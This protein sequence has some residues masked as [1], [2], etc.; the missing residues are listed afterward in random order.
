MTQLVQAIAQVTADEN[1]TVT[2]SDFGTYIF[3]DGETTFQAT[4]AGDKVVLRGAWTFEHNGETI[5][6][7]ENSG[8]SSNL[9]MGTAPITMAKNLNRRFLTN[10]KAEMSSLISE[11]H[12]VKA[13]T[14]HS[15]S[16]Y[17]ELVSSV[18]TNLGEFVDC[19]E[20]DNGNL[21]FRI[22]DNL[23]A[24]VEGDFVNITLSVP[25]ETAGDILE[26][27][28]TDYPFEEE[29]IEEEELEEEEVEET[30]EELTAV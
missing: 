5:F 7:T 14:A 16:F 13:T 28:L 21:G 8:L 9:S 12:K 19:L 10:Y 18:E 15:E 6:L 25:Y 2:V 27:F 4:Q 20:V 24:K 29:E 1:W 11:W 22:G 3:S 30:A 26:T 17:S 23:E